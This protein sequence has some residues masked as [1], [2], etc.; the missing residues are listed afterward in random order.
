MRRIRARSMSGRLSMMDHVIE[1]RRRDR[2]EASTP[3]RRTSGSVLYSHQG[4]N[5]QTSTTPAGGIVLASI[6][7]SGAPKPPLAEAA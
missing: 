4:A 2:A 5:V 6:T 1:A 3:F 7:H